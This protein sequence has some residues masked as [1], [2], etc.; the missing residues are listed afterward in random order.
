MAAPAADELP[1]KGIKVQALQS[2]I[3]E[4][5]FQTMLVKGPGKLGY[6]VQPIKEVEYPTAHIAVANG[7]ATFMAVHWDPLHKDYYKNAGGDA[8]LLRKGQYAGLPRRAI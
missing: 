8:K 3:A 2:S 7:D 5:T 1:G 4:E 6:E